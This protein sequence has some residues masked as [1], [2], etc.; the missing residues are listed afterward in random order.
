MTKKVWYSIEIECIKETAASTLRVGE[1]DLVCKV[2]S[3]GL[4]FLVAADLEK[5]Y[6]Q[7]YFKIIVK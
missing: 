2:K 7:E 5:T 1:K 6:K 4:A 3:K